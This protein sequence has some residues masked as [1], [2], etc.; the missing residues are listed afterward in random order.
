MKSQLDKYIDACN[1]EDH[2]ISMDDEQVY[3]TDCKW[4]KALPIGVEIWEVDEKI[5]Y[6]PFEDECDIDNC[7]DSQAFKY[8]PCYEIKE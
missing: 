6:C 2:I 8:R 5:P 3:C 1:A 4:F 7:E